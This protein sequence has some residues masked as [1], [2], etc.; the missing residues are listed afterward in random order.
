[1]KSSVCLVIQKF[2]IEIQYINLNLDISIDSIKYAY[3]NSVK[4]TICQLCKLFTVNAI[5]KL[6]CGEPMR[7]C[8]RSDALGGVGWA[9]GAFIGE[10]RRGLYKRGQSTKQCAW[11]VAQVQVG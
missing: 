8:T 10:N 9:K 2:Q 6:H 3:L 4:F 1:M 11:Q 7:Q 5:I